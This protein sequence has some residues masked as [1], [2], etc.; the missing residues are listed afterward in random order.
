MNGEEISLHRK[1]YAQAA[2]LVLGAH[3]AGV[4]TVSSSLKPEERAE[5]ARQARV[6]VAG[7]LVRAALRGMDCRLK[8]ARHFEALTR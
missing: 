7:E 6:A 3:A 4:G 8:S 2:L 1:V 5:L